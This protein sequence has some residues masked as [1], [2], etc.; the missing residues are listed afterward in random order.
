MRQMS[1][2]RKRLNGSA[3]RLIVLLRLLSPANLGHSLSYLRIYGV[4]LCF[5][6]TVF[7]LSLALGLRRSPA[8]PTSQ[9]AAYK[10]KHGAGPLKRRV[11][12]CAP[13][14]DGL[15]ETLRL[16]LAAIKDGLVDSLR[17]EG[18]TDG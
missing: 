3:S 16:E 6:R 7:H 11:P 17:G 1:E 15:Q 14:L 10:T 4:R 2:N 13:S 9:L 12:E 5:A 8:L 18:R